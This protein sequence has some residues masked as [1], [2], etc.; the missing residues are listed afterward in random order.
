MGE[1]EQGGM[2]R[3]V[4]VVGLI[5]LIAIIITGGIVGLRSSL[6]TNTLMAVDAGHNLVKLQN[7]SIKQSA[8]V[9]NDDKLQS[10]SIKDNGDNDATF[11][12]RPT[13]AVQGVFMPYNIVAKD[14]IDVNDSWTFSLDMK[15][16]SGSNLR[17]YQLGLEGSVVKSSTKPALN[18]TWQHYVV[19]GTRLQRS[20]TAVIYFRNS[21]SVPIT[22]DIK[23]IELHRSV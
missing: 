10:I 3:T 21:S 9:L 4:V 15:S 5:A 8:T 14:Y 17:I 20:G 18:D 12:L 2:L 7:N 6:R 1:N 13:T 11:T 22:L 19:N 23:N 16:S